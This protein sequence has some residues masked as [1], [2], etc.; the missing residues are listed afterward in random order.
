MSI[1]QRSVPRRAPA[2]L[3]GR[4]SRPAEVER[5]QIGHAPGPHAHHEVGLEQLIVA[6]RRRAYGQTLAAPLDSGHARLEPHF[7]S[8]FDE[9]L[10]LSFDPIHLLEH[11]HLR[12]CLRSEV[13][14]LGD[15]EATAEQDD[16][17]RHS[18]MLGKTRAGYD[19][20]LAS[21]AQVHRN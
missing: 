16:R 14:E 9:V 10:D 6:V 4:H 15:D 12:A 19:V 13:G 7:N 8:D 17:L 3:R 11:R 1:P 21:N 20:F 5:L 18:I 2:S